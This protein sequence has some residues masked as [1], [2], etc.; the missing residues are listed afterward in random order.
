MVASLRILVVGIVLGCCAL[1]TAQ[2]ADKNTISA[3][4]DKI[5]KARAELDRA[6]DLFKAGAL[7][8]ASLIESRLQLDKAQVELA[9]LQD[10]FATAEKSLQDAVVAREALLDMARQ[11]VEA[12]VAARDAATK[13]RADLA[14]ARIS[15][16][17]LA[18]VRAR[19]SELKAARAQFEA[20]SAGREAI[21]AAEKALD[22]AKKRWHD[23]EA[24]N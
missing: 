8:P 20:G 10:D 23:N 15:L 12:G 18:I 11:Q 24:G 4:Q 19:E 9:R 16:E 17:S 13:A 6:H 7:G 5:A 1:G 14:N 22:A 3:A 2:T 21:E